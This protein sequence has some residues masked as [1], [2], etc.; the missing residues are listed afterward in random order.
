MPFTSEWV[1]P[2]IFL[3]HKGVTVYHAYK[4]NDLCNGRSN[5]WF[6]MSEKDEVDHQFDVRELPTWKPLLKKVEETVK[7]P[8]LMSAENFPVLSTLSIGANITNTKSDPR[9]KEY[10]KEDARWQKYREIMACAELAN[11]KKAIRQA[12]EQKILKQA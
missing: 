6:T 10:W 8:K 4:D 7:R 12:I 1:P 2:E 9:F 11:T 5:Y 3:T